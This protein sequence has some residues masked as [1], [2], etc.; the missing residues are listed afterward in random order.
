MNSLK[1]IK[2]ASFAL[3]FITLITAIIVATEESLDAGLIEK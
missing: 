2:V 3:E 1:L